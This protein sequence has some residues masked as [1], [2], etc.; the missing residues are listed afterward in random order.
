MCFVSDSVTAEDNTCSE[1][2]EFLCGSGQ[3]ISSDKRCNGISEC[4]DGRDE[5]VSV[6]GEL[7]VT[8]IRIILVLP[9]VSLL[10]R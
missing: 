3:C 4:I 9:I 6:C 1:P 10:Q 8:C 7:L 5:S 2:D